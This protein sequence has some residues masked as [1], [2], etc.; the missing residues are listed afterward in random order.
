MPPNGACGTSILKQWD[1]PPM[2]KHNSP[3]QLM[4]LT[5]NGK[6][7]ANVV[8]VFGLYVKSGGLGSSS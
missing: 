4:T 7:K 1:A 6:F 8:K 3:S 2:M 5:L